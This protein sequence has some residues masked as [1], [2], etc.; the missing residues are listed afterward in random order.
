MW[1][2]RETWA[3]SPFQPQAAAPSLPKVHSLPQKPLA[4]EEDE[5]QRKAWLPWASHTW[6]LR[7]PSLPAAP[8][9]A[10]PSSQRAPPAR[11]SASAPRVNACPYQQVHGELQPL[12]NLGRCRQSRLKNTGKGK[13]SS[14]A[15]LKQACSFFSL[16]PRFNSFISSICPL[17]TDLS[18]Y[19]SNSWP[20][21][22]KRHLMSYLPMPQ[23]SQHSQ[24]PEA[25][26]LCTGQGHYQALFTA[27]T[28][29]LVLLSMNQTPELLKVFI[30][31]KN[32][33]IDCFLVTTG[34]IN[35]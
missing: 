10:L 2:S 25:S 14:S 23:Q 24:S 3:S 27:Q 17:M 26:V 8:D 21:N 22:S 19:R 12:M 5:G 34:F 32:A 11:A 15:S 29:K 35:H 20:T 31:I 6:A 18:L 4:R 9:Q 33:V 1:A 7:E 13:Q 30:N 28:V 16:E